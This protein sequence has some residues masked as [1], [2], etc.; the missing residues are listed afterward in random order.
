MNKHVAVLIKKLVKIAPPSIVLSVHITSELKNKIYKQ[1]KY[2]NVQKCQKTNGIYLPQ[3]KTIIYPRQNIYWA[4][5]G[6]K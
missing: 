2:Y 6:I 1:R 5:L 4:S 3:S